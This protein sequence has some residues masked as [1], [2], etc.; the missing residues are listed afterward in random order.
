M[1]KKT[2]SELRAEVERQEKKI[3]HLSAKSREQKKIRDMKVKLFKM[4]HQRELDIA[5]DAR[6]G[7]TSL[8]KAMSSGFKKMQS[9]EGKI[10]KKEKARKKRKPV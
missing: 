6:K 4:K 9:Y 7:L 3:K 8:A 5:K 2:L 1:A 10:E